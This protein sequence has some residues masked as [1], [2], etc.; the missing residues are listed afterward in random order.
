M[1]ALMAG[2]NLRFDPFPLSLS[3]QRVKEDASAALSVVHA[4]NS[5]VAPLRSVEREKHA[6]A[7]DF[8]YNMKYGQNRRL[9]SLRDVHAR[10]AGLSQPSG[11]SRGQSSLLIRLKNPLFADKKQPNLAR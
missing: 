2:T 11:R 10:D 1:P 7:L 6:N 5:L 4:G 9:S 8:A 3:R